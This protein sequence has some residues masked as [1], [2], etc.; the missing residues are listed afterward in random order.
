MDAPT[1]TDVMV[2]TVADMPTAVA[3]VL[4]ARG[5][6]LPAHNPAM[7]APVT[8]TAAKVRKSL[9]HEAVALVS[10]CTDAG[11]L[12][13]LAND[14]RVSVREAVCV[15]PYTRH[16]TRMAAFAQLR[17]DGHYPSFE[18]S[19]VAAVADLDDLHDLCTHFDVVARFS[20]SVVV[21]R[22]DAA[23]APHF[24]ESFETLHVDACH[25]ALSGDL[26]V[27]TVFPHVSRAAWKSAAQRAGVLTESA[28]D[29]LSETGM[30]D[31]ALMAARHR[32]VN[33]ATL[34]KVAAM[35]LAPDPKQLVAAA[36]VLVAN[37]AG[38]PA[39]IGAHA[40]EYLTAHDAIALWD[41]FDDDA[42]AAALA[43]G[44]TKGRWEWEDVAIDFVVTN[45]ASFRDEW[46]ADAAAIV[47]RS[48]RSFGRLD[49]RL[50]L[51]TVRVRRNTSGARAKLVANGNTM[52]AN[53]ID[54][55][56]QAGSLS[57]DGCS[58]ALRCLPAIRLKWIRG[59]Y[60]QFPYD[61]ARLDQ[62]TAKSK[63]SRRGDWIIDAIAEVAERPWGRD[64]VLDHPRLISVMNL[65]PPSKQTAAA[66]VMFTL[67]RDEIGDVPAAWEQV[68]AMLPRWPGTLRQL[69]ATVSAT[70]GSTTPM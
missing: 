45:S 9:R 43:H 69:A 1:L 60:Q 20:G 24:L 57:D 40:V 25:A 4:H 17:E 33:A 55:R 41:V 7:A 36:L 35:T 27:S 15:N 65:R 5:M 63:T 51:R 8:V 66:E 31:E 37:G 54:R 38:V 46:L 18:W 53:E 50:L 61:P 70:I 64:A 58:A 13:Q 32:S 6:L 14:R 62:V 59:A 22:L 48:S 3:D 67:L 19:A 16:R 28:F 34:T 56:L 23:T 26:D 42:R 21:A 12:D 29:G 47:S 52:A 30:F 10:Y 11:T 44:A 39:T 2:S 68:A 49:E